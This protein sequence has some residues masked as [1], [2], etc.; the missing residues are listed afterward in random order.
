MIQS[1]LVQKA[2]N[3]ALNSQWQSALEINEKILEQFPD[4]LDSLNRLARACFELGDISRS[5]KIYKEVLNH[6]P[7][8]V[9]ALKNIKRFQLIKG[10]TDELSHTLVRQA[11]LHTGS[12]PVTSF[13][14]EP[15][16]TKVI[17]LTRLAEP[18]VL[19]TIHCGD[20][21]ALI[22]K[23]R[24]VHVFTEQNAYIGRL[25]DDIAFQLQYFIKSGN[26]YEAH[27]K[28]VQ[29]NAVNVFIKEA[30]RIPEFASRPTFSYIADA[31]LTFPDTPLESDSSLESEEESNEEQ[32]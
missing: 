22:P 10:N 23:L 15:G 13:I 31:V 9:I 25:P 21:V 12:K 24:G 16:K 26:K 19:F 3:A 2:I 14:E 32:I 30:Y 28:Q 20:P 7:Y 17:Q 29:T 6:D 5:K 11:K 18:H 8:N 1:V 4:D 27:V